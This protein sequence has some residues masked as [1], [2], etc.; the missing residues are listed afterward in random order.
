[1]ISHE[2]HGV[3]Y[4]RSKTR[5][6]TVAPRRWTEAVIDQ[7][8]NLPIVHEACLLKITF[9]LPANKFPSDFPYG[10]DLDNL[11]KRTLDALSE[12]IFRNAS[13][14]DS[15][16]VALIAMKTKVADEEKTGAHIEVLP[17]KGEH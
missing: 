11:L 2:I 17:V 16:S 14:K 9:R 4:A 10:P 6:D 1:M 8:K 3:P 5:G 12:T 13:G 15:C 7:T